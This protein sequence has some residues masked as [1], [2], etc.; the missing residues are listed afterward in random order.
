MAATYKTLYAVAGTGDGAG[1]AGGF[2]DVGGKLFGT[3]TYGG[4]T[5]N[6]TI[7]EL[8]PTTGA[9]TQLYNFAGGSDGF[10]PQGDL[11]KVGTL[12]YGVTEYGGTNG[13]GTI[14]SYDPATGSE[15]VLWNFSGGEGLDPIC[16][17][18]PAGGNL[19]GTTLYG[20]ANGTG[21]VFAFAPTAGTVT[22]IYSFGADGDAMNPTT[23]LVALGGTLYG[24]GTQGGALGQG[25]IYAVNPAS[26]AESV[27]YSFGG[28]ADGASPAAPLLAVNGLLFG[29]TEYGG[30]SGEG[31]VF[32]FDPASAKE[33]VLH[34]FSADTDGAYPASGLSYASGVFYG[35]T[36]TS[37]A[38][39]GGT[40]F[41]LAS[42]G[43]TLTVLH[44]FGIGDGA[45]ASA[46]PL[47]L[48]G[49]L[50][51]T[52]GY[53]G[54]NAQGDV[55]SLSQAGDSFSVLHSFTG[56]TPVEDV[57]LNLLS[58]KIYALASNGGPA[59]LG[60]ATSISTTS[61]RTVPLH[62]FTAAG[63][64]VPF[65]SMTNDAGLLYGLSQFGGTAGCGGLGCGTIFKLDHKTG[66]RT[67]VFAFPAGTDPVC[68]SGDF[69]RAEGVLIGTT[70]SGGT[71]GYGTVFK[72]D[73]ATGTH[74]ILYNFA[75][76]A[77]GAY[78]FGS[79]I[80]VQGEIYG[81]TIAGGAHGAGTIFKISAH[82]SVETVLYSFSGSAES[83]GDGDASTP[84]SGL[85]DVGG[86]LYGTT[87]W[88]GAYG[89]GTVYAFNPA[90][91]K[92]SI[93]HSFNIGGADG[94]QPGS[95]LTYMNGLLYGM[96][97]YGGGKGT[98]CDFNVCGTVVSVD[99]TSGE[100]TILHAFTGG[101]DGGN[102]PYAPL[103]ALG[104]VLYGTTGSAGAHG[105]GTVFSLAP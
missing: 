41:S 37:G 62:A 30:A 49:V 17:L 102:P 1:P 97:V 82:T 27:V 103:V 8:D 16:T 96:T 94:T 38:S 80:D 9:L 11:V 73:P 100:E 60:A 98:G 51:G 63:G 31:T 53:G 47:L 18:L 79:L 64:S 57:G 85:I 10:F 104:G 12:L 15:T 4:A 28:G 61:G 76:G 99:P 65:G 72:L 81:T 105:L 46:A 35:T 14:F 2:I 43:D 40:V 55:Y 95:N 7:V 23:G 50:Y 54:A 29:T 83:A 42:R 22:A 68:G 13:N 26:G 32:R 34:S 67:Q 75:G 58:S 91:G 24:T 92:A 59:G 3:T 71:N 78:P 66:A 56:S 25:A 6:G 90:T 44:A 45:D 39:G 19:Y 69:A 86:M 5:G 33:S 70:C 52:T 88:G 21:T 87:F 77:D 48:N 84:Y 101:T 74:T 36:L 20:G 89:W 93:L